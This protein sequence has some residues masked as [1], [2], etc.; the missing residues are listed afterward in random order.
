LKDDL[1][2]WSIFLIRILEGCQNLTNFFKSLFLSSFNNLWKGLCYIEKNRNYYPKYFLIS[3]WEF[4]FYVHLD[5]PIFVLVKLTLMEAKSDQSPAVVRVP[6]LKK[7]YR[8]EYLTL[9]NKI[10]PY[11]FRNF[12]SNIEFDFYNFI[13]R[14]K[15]A[16]NDQS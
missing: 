12:K 13:I 2:L 11:L 15:L 6:A 4:C 14:W 8:L 7:A 3:Y 10:W 16:E 9:L 1:V 5:S